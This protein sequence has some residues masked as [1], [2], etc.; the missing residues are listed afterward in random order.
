MKLTPGRIVALGA[1][2]PVVFI[3]AVATVAFVAP[4][5]HD[6]HSAGATQLK[7]SMVESDLRGVWEVEP[8]QSISDLRC[9]VWARVNGGTPCPDDIAQKYF[10]AVTQAP[11][12]LYM[13]WTGCLSWRGGGAILH[14][15]GYNVEYFSSSRKFVIHCY[16]AEGWV[17]PHDSLFG[18]AAQPPANLL[19]IPTGSIS[20][21]DVQI[22]E[23]DRLEHLVR[24]AS[25]EFKL[26][27]ATIST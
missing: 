19:V 3:V 7:T 14:W 13:I 27:N 20:P 5:A 23:D 26:A 4:P 16:L 2:P 8:S 9:K 25:N 12:T 18:V 11:N 21:G 24:D 10:P 22:W 6:V 15:Q 1:I 17:A